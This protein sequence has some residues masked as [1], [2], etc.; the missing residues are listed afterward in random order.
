MDIQVR[1][2]L[3]TANLFEELKSLYQDSTGINYTKSDVL[4]KAILDNY[5]QWENVNWVDLSIAKIKTAEYDIPLG[6]LRPKLIITQESS[7][8]LSDFQKEMTKTFDVR[9]V[10]IGVCIKLILKYA[11]F[12]HSGNKNKEKLN[13]FLEQLKIQFNKKYI[14]PQIQQAI[15]EYHD[16]IIIYLDSSFKSIS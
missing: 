8:I 2:S 15:N 5:S 10:A 3:E 6:A 4:M 13:I 9:S 16:E 11:L 14:D 12:E 7:E 1:I